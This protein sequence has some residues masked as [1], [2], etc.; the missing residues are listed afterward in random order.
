M[1]KCSWRMFYDSGK[2]DGHFCVKSV[3][4]VAIARFTA[5]S[6]ITENSPVEKPTKA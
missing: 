2:S 5:L 4:V 6:E 1:L 3:G